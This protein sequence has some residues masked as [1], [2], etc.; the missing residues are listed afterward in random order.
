LLLVVVLEMHVRGAVTR[1]VPCLNSAAQLMSLLKCALELRSSRVTERNPIS[2]RS[3]AVCSI[4]VDVSNG[5]GEQGQGV[6]YGKITLVDLAGSERNYETTQM[7]GSQ[8]KESAEINFALMALKNCFRSYS[9][10]LEQQQGDALDAPSPQQLTNQP[11]TDVDDV[12]AAHKTTKAQPVSLRNYL[13]QQNNQKHTEISISTDFKSTV[14]NSSNVME[15]SLSKKSASSSVRIPYRETLLTRV[16]KDCFTVS[17]TNPHRTAIVATVSPTS[18]DLLHSVN[19][20]EHVILMSPK[21]QTLKQSVSVEVPMVNGAAY[22]HVPISQWTPQQV[23]AW[24]T[25]TDRGRFAQLVLPQNLDGKGLLSL[26]EHRLNSLISQQL[27]R[28]ARREVEG[29]AWVFLDEDQNDI[30]D[31]EI[32]Q[33]NTSSVITAASIRASTYDKIGRAL[34]SA[35]R[36]QQ[37]SAVALADAKRRHSDTFI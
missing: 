34:W 15:S 25:T 31:E 18:T 17:T 8:H 2:S 3:H 19:T 4:E 16:L 14:E 7:S 12:I 27:S 33:R 13:R 26:S 24:L 23:A 29:S 11:I 37:L 6:S 21:L 36:R 10:L 9:K 28:A 22:A 35:I 1:T 20:L 32:P 5:N 30:I